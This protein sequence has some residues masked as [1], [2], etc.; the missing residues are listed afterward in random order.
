MSGGGKVLASS[1]PLGALISLESYKFNGLATAAFILVA[2]KLP[3][4]FSLALSK[5]ALSF[6]S[7]RVVAYMPLSV[8]KPPQIHICVKVFSA[9]EL[10][11]IFTGER[12][13]LIAR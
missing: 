10:K 2:S 3:I 8:L 1:S 13:L 11:S 12:I 6:D 4:M 7:S 5:K 9:S